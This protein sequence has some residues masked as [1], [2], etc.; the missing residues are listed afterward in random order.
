MR[1]LT[2][3][4][5]ALLAGCD[6]QDP[7]QIPTEVW[8]LFPFDGDR[9]W[10]FV[11]DDAPYNLVGE[12]VGSE[13]RGPVNAYAV[14]YT[15]ACRFESKQCVSGDEVLNLLMSS[16]PTDGIQVY[17]YVFDGLRVEMRPPLLISPDTTLRNNP[18]VTQTAG[19]E[20]S[21]V[22]TGITTCPSTATNDWQ[23]GVFEISNNAENG[24][25]PLA[26]TLY[27]ARGQGLVAMDIAMDDF[28]LW[29][30][31][32]STCEGDCNGRW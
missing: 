14:S 18:H 17:S 10:R 9:T 29:E 13:I 15:K 16:D 1:T 25:A 3:A 32:D 4:V 22:F 2:I 11:T 5:L 12:I 31:A 28:G 23:C 26:G 24:G 20:W 30:N 27:A 6:S 8:N 21:T 19:A 7:L